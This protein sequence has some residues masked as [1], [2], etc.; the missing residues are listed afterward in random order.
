VYWG[1][2][3]PCIIASTVGG[4]VLGCVVII[5][6]TIGGVCVGPSLTST[7]LDSAYVSSEKG[8]S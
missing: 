6:N 7:S 3:W 4:G 5:V 1:S 8:D 2:A